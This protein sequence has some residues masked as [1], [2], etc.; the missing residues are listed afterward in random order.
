MTNSSVVP[1][2]SNVVNQWVYLA[3]LL[4]MVKGYLQDCGPPP[5]QLHHLKVSPQPRW[6]L[7]LSHI[8]GGLPPVEPPSV[9]LSTS[10]DLQSYLQLGQSHIDMAGRCRREPW[11]Q[12]SW[13]QQ[14]LTR[15]SCEEKVKS[16]QAGWEFFDFESSHGFSDDDA[17]PS[18]LDDRSPHQMLTLW[19][20]VLF[21][22]PTRPR[23]RSPMNHDVSEV[24]TGS[25]Q[26]KLG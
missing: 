11:K 23:Y 16:Q 6:W 2:K 18:C 8:D 9:Y 4:S 26:V 7:R 15:L 21:M 3:Y 1:L 24:L 14:S 25:S 17:K 13:V 10:W 12:Q 22:W 20:R 19:M 5:K